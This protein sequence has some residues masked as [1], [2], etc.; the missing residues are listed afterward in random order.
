MLTP[1][2][3]IQ[4]RICRLIMAFILLALAYYFHSYFIL[5]VALFVFLK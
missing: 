2:I 1:N 4:G 5:L 3:E